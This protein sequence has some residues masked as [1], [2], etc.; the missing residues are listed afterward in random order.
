MAGDLSDLTDEEH[1]VIDA[2]VALV[3]RRAYPSRDPF[4]YS[5]PIWAHVYTKVVI[6]YK[7]RYRGRVTELNVEL[8]KTLATASVTLASIRQKVREQDAAEEAQ[9][10]RRRQRKPRKGVVRGHLRLVQD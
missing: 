10:Q 8:I 4:A 1:M 5:K 2:A 7:D 3:F 9:R 6:C